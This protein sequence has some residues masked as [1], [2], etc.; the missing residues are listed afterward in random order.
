MT[1]L[2]ASLD[3]VEAGRVVVAFRREEALLQQHGFLHAGVAT[4]IVDSACGYAALTLAPENYE[5]LTV[6]FK[7]NFLRP[8]TGNRFEARGRVIKPGRL[9]MV[10]E[11]EVW[12]TDPGNV[13]VAK[14]NATM[15]VQPQK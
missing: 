13:L 14:M 1:T 6:E 12:E 3:V 15:I 2:G 7:T 4:S 8:A 10:C 5:V 11:G 9:I